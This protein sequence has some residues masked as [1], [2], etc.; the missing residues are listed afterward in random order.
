MYFPA[1]PQR[2]YD[3]SGPEIKL[4]F[5]LRN[6]VDRML[7]H[8]LMC[9]QKGYETQGFY[10]ALKL[11]KTRISS[12][13]K[14]NARFSYLGRC[15]YALQVK[16]FLKHFPKENMMFIIFETQFIGNLKKTIEKLLGFL[17]LPLI[18]LDLGVHANE[19]CDQSCQA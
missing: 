18:D 1:V 8:Y 19:Q 17:E 10:E 14:N 3:A 11:E 5:I 9:K 6:P 4:I 12:S 16:R 13:E 2:I 7:S 15:L